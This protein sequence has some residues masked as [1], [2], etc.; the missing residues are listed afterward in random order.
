MDAGNLLILVL[1]AAFAIDR[2]SHA[3]VYA[4]S[5][6]GVLK[7]PTQK[8]ESRRSTV[9]YFILASALSI[10]FLIYWEPLPIQRLLGSPV[11]GFL[12]KLFTFIVLV[13]GSDGIS[14]VLDST[15]KKS[16]PASPKSESLVVSGE[17]TVQEG[18][19]A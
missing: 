18:P 8:D 4:V 5:L 17:V 1:L 3:I 19:K 2:T 13:G 16:A 12:E 9:L 6:T 15:F 10:L 7:S 14:S 11:P